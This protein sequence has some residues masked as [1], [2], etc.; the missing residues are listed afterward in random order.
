MTPRFL[1]CSR[2]RCNDNGASRCCN[3]DMTL[4]ANNIS[5]RAIVLFTRTNKHSSFEIV[6]GFFKR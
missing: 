5:T 4:C 3:E 6:T 1:L 2:T